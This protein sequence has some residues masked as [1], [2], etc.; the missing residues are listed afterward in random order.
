MRA[1]RNSMNPLDWIG[2]GGS[3]TSE[4]ELRNTARDLYDRELALYQDRLERGIWTQAKF[5]AAKAKLDAEWLGTSAQIDEI[6]DEFTDPQKLGENLGE[7]AAAAGDA[8]GG[9]VNR[10]TNAAGSFVGRT[11]LGFPAW[12]W[13]LALVG[14]FLYFGGATLIRARVARAAA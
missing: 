8:V 10:V 2:W 1:H 11:L 7:S 3:G 12:A 5:D 4:V 9:V 13:A 6:S 14:A